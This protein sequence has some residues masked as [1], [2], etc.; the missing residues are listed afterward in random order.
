[1]PNS[2]MMSTGIFGIVAIIVMGIVEQ[3]APTINFSKEVVGFPLSMWIVA[4]GMWASG[5]LKK[6]NRT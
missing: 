1:M 3:V 6:E 5:W 4:L 2:K